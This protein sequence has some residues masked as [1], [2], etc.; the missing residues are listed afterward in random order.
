VVKWQW[1][2]FSSEVTGIYYRKASNYIL[3][4]ISMDDECYGNTEWDLQNET[5][6]TL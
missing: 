6:L 2:T 1:S 5:H 4:R 3:I